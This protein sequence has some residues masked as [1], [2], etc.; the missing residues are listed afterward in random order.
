MDDHVR[1]II[2]Q[3]LEFLELFEALPK[4][5]RDALAFSH[6]ILNADKANEL[7]RRIK[8]RTERQLMPEK[9]AVLPIV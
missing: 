1:E 2:T 6:V 7:V 4:L 3:R 8:D 5:L 9:R